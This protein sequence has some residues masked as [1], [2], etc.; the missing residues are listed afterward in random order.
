MASV[1]HVN[2]I[3]GTTGVGSQAG[4]PIQMSGDAATLGS[5]VNFPSG[6]IIEA[7]QTL[8]RGTVGV[9]YNDGYFQP[10]GFEVTTAAK[11]A[12]VKFLINYA[13]SLGSG[14]ANDYN[15]SAG[16]FK[17]SDSD[18]LSETINSGIKSTL[19]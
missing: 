15:F 5:G 14:T 6:H 10:S 13:V 4:S 18:P 2:A 12:N 11:V 1:L 8:F 9:A 17:D 19:N 16:I 7:K 3:T